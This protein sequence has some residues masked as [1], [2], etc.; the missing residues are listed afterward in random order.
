MKRICVFSL[1][2]LFFLCFF[3]CGFSPLGDDGSEVSVKGIHS[4]SGFTEVTEG[5]VRNAFP[6]YD[7]RK[8][9]YHFYA[10]KSSGEAAAAE[11]TGAKN[12]F[13]FLL[14]N[15]EWLIYG[16]VY[17]GSALTPETFRTGAKIFSGSSTLSLADSSGDIADF[18]IVTE[19]VSSENA[20]GSAN[21]KICSSVPA[22]KYAKAEWTGPG[23][24]TGSQILDFSDPSRKDG[25]GYYDFFNFGGSNVPAGAYTVKFSFYDGEVSSASGVTGKIVCATVKTVN[26][27]SSLATDSWSDDGIFVSGGSGKIVLSEDCIR[28]SKATILYVSA[29]ASG[30]GLGID[31]SAPL[32][33]LDSAFDLIFN[34]SMSDV[35]VCILEGT[36]ADFTRGISLSENVK[37]ISVTTYL[38]DGT[39]NPPALA[40][41]RRGTLRRPDNSARIDDKGIA[42]SSVRFENINIEG[43]PL[44]AG[45]ADISPLLSLGSAKLNVLNCHITDDYFAC[46]KGK[47]SS[48]C[49]ENVE[50]QGSKEPGSKAIHLSDAETSLEIKGCAIKNYAE[51]ICLEAEKTNAV[52]SG[53][54]LSGNDVAIKA[55]KFASLELSGITLKNNS[56]YGIK[57]CGTFT[58]SGTCDLDDIFYFDFTGTSGICVNFEENYKNSSTSNA[59]YISMDSKKL[60]TGLQVLSGKNISQNRQNFAVQESGW[61][62]DDNGCLA[63]NQENPTSF[64]VD[65]VSGSDSNSGTLAKPYKTLDAAVKKAKETNERLSGD[66]NELYIFINKNIVSDGSASALQNDSLCSI[67]TDPGAKK[68][69]L[70]V[71][72]SS[73]SAVEINAKMAS[74][75]FYITGKVNIVLKNLSLYGGSVASKGGAIYLDGTDAVLTL[76]NC[77]VGKTNADIDGLKDGVQNK[78]YLT[79]GTNCS[80]KAAEGGGIYVANG[81]RLFLSASKILNCYADSDSG[82]GGGIYV[83][84]S[85][86]EINDGSEIYANGAAGSDGAAI[87]AKNSNVYFNKGTVRHHFSNAF[88]NVPGIYLSNTSFDMYGGEIR[89]NY[90]SESNFGSGVF[91]DDAASSVTFYG[92]SVNNNSSVKDDKSSCD[93]GYTA[94]IQEPV[95]SIS[96]DAYI[97][98]IYS[99]GTCIKILSVLTG[100]SDAKKCAVYAQTSEGTEILKAGDPSVNLSG[101]M[102]FFALYKTDL[103]SPNGLGLILD[104]TQTKAVVGKVYKISS[105]ENYS[106]VSDVATAGQKTFSISTESELNKIAEWTSG[107]GNDFDGITLVLEKDIALSCDKDDKTTHFTPIGINSSF[108]GTFDG[109]GHKISNLYVDRAGRAGL[110]ASV[111]GA[112]IKNLTVEG[113]V[114]GSSYA[115]SD[116]TGVGGIVGYSF[117]QIVIENCVSNVNVSS[118]CKNTGGIC[119]YVND[120]DSV[121]RN[122]INIGEIKSD[123]DK[124]G[125]I[126][127]N[128]GIVYNCANFGTVS[129]KSN[130]AGIAGYTEK[131]VSL[132]YN[133]GAIS[134][135]PSDGASSA[136]AIAN[137]AG[138]DTDF[139]HYCYFKEGTADAAFKGTST[140]PDNFD[141]SDPNQQNLGLELSNRIA[142]S[143]Y[144]AYCSPWN[145]TYTFDG[146][147]YPVCV[148]IK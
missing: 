1:T 102:D 11:Y 5:K 108:E 42:G 54:E 65:P 144:K 128:P 75:I 147:E 16:D 94:Y 64:Y 51:G 118:S 120:V 35:T 137:V 52:V 22:V 124:T 47:S 121:I 132:C 126:S 105:Y 20:K 104:P 31:R 82:G 145:K 63:Q 91:I 88:A 43:K 6:S 7:D 84:D 15:G 98:S 92:G 26:I 119:G 69:S 122:C 130:V 140:R 27:L 99:P 141:F 67:S 13:S 66:Q 24:I 28:I 49:F 143:A 93:V 48:I 3:G 59:V 123:S 58:L 80:N 33:S 109:N 103:K 81:G 73:S 32:N 23:G 8:L 129:G 112:S 45:S 100:F 87:C 133:A 106:D 44:T 117:S 79:N 71:A 114:V 74:R 95:V 138:T 125:G 134:I 39:I 57:T 12:S 78:T 40:K 131:D 142:T 113:T 116:S 34:F 29:S 4:V 83:A 19:I 77:I 90:C 2:I 86:L 14:E 127:G 18:R 21:L 135:S 146:V 76:E 111:Y 97:E 60:R 101:C 10:K 62:I 9:F 70:T 53:S 107:Y 115:G 41:D 148:E 85:S 55:S 56:G 17:Y 110:F 50:F 37:N 72:S 38:A 89:D 96:G 30:N 136:A 46:V 61:Q 68:L 139:Y 36:S 25:I